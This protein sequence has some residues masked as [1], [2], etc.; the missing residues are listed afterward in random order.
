M[1]KAKYFESKM[2]SQRYGELFDFEHRLSIRT[3]KLYTQNNT[4]DPTRCID[5]PRF[6]SLES[7]SND[8]AAGISSVLVAKPGQNDEGMLSHPVTKVLK[9][10]MENQ[11]KNVAKITGSMPE[12]RDPIPRWKRHY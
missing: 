7:T 1:K 2:P 9:S 10:H 11:A 8:K 5:I 12:L 6:P 3:A 4:F